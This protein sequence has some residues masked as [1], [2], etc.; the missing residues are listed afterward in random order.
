MSAVGCG[1]ELNHAVT[2]TGYGS[3]NGKD[4]WNIKN[5]WG[6]SWGDNGYI[7]LLKTSEKGPGICGVLMDASFPK[8]WWT[9]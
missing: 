2:C 7:R 8:L 5:S 6:G 3:E 1:T 4:F 9:Y